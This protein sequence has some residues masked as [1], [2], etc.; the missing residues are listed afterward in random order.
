[1]PVARAAASRLRNRE[2]C[3]DIRETRSMVMLSPRFS[4]TASLSRISM[5]KNFPPSTPDCG[6]S[7]AVSCRLNVRNFK[8]QLQSFLLV[9]RL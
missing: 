9:H 3:L 7:F 1:M 2:F 8:W 4:L 5:P 6:A